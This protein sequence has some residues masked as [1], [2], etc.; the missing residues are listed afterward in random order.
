VTAALGFALAAAL[1]AASPDAGTA[2]PAT[3]PRNP[4]S[5]TADRLQV[6]NKQGQAIYT[7]HVVAVRG[8]AR[9]RCGRLVA[10][11]GKAQEIVR[12][13]CLGGAEI[14]DRDRW[15]RG[16]L[17]VYEA[18]R[19]VLEVTGSPQARQGPNTMTGDRVLFDLGK[20][21]IEVEHPRATVEISGRTRGGKPRAPRDGGEAPPPP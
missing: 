17:A 1:L 3:A 19:G 10:T 15:A 14:D 9:L 13:E 4:V 5:I 2:V 21:T 12:L 11:Y 16:D 6:L 18:A 7:G 20:D 8:T